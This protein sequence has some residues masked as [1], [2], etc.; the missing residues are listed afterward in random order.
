MSHKIH[1]WFSLMLMAAL[2]L[3]SIT[4]LVSSPS[5]VLGVYILTILV[6]GLI[7]VY[8]FCAK[9][10]IRIT[11][12]R[13]IIIGPLTRILPQRKQAPYSTLDILFTIIAVLAIFGFPQFSLISK[14][15]LF[16][17]FWITAILLVLEITLFICRGCGNVYCPVRRFS[18]HTISG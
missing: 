5:I 14:M 17:S 2:F 15:P 9:C 16:I 8:S 12:C 10:P 3:I 7:I 4:S 1:G 18:G 11:G 6:S 13:H